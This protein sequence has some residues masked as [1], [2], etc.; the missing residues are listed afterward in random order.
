MKEKRGWIQSLCLLRGFCLAS[1]MVFP[2]VCCSGCKVVRIEEE[3]GKAVEY[4]IVK[5]EEIPE[6][7][8]SLIEEKKQQEFQMTYQIGEDLYLVRGYGQQMTGGYSIQVLSLSASDSAI[9][10]ETKLLG[11]SAENQNRVPSYP[12]I[13]VKMKYREQPV[14]F[15]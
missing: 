7:I 12:V 9:F 8:E 10:L 1:S 11:S 14:C 4:T 3:E 6:E 5:Q 13:V 15:Q 2:A